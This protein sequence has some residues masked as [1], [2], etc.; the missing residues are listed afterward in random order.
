MSVLP[1][2]TRAVPPNAAEPWNRPTATTSPA[3]PVAIAAKMSSSAPPK[4][5]AQRTLPAVSYFARKASEAPALLRVVLPKR[6]EPRKLPATKRP[7]PP[8]VATA[9]PTSMSVPPIARA[10]CP[11]GGVVVVVGGRDVLVVV[12]VG[13]VVVV[14]GRDVLVVVVVGRVVVVGGRVVLVVG[15]DVLV[16]DVDGRDVVVVEVVAVPPVITTMAVSAVAD[17]APALSRTHSESE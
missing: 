14:V 15:R 12:V 16:D 10:H 17:H 8:S 13:R 3:A 4:R 2:E 11:E 6:A 9:S 7:L 1:L 5:F